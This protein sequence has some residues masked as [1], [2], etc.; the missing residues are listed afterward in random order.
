MSAYLGDLKLVAGL[1]IVVL[2]SAVG[3]DA[4]VFGDGELLLAVMA[5]ANCLNP[6][7]L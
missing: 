3:A 4:F 1:G 2:A 5:F 7:D 6:V